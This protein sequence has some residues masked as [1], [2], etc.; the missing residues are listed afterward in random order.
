MIWD[1]NQFNKLILALR[2]LRNSGDV[3]SEPELSAIKQKIFLS[4]AAET[5]SS[6][7][8]LTWTERK[9]KIM[10]YIISILVG[11]SLV[12]GTA[13]ASSGSKPGDLLYPIKRA[14]EKVQ[15]TVAASSE[16]KANLQASFAQERLSELE[17]LEAKN[18]SVHTNS[19]STRVSNSQINNDEGQETEFKAEAKVEV[20]NAVSVLQKLK[21]DL[22]NKGNTEGAKAVAKN[23]SR[24]QSRAK[25]HN[26]KIEVGKSGGEAE[27]EDRESRGS[28]VGSG[29]S[30]PATTSPPRVERENKRSKRSVSDFKDE[31][32]Q[33]GREDFEDDTNDDDRTGDGISPVVIT[34]TSSPSTSA[35]AQTAATYTMVQVQAANTASKCWSVISGKVYNLTSWISQHPGGSSAILGL[36]G[37]DG[38]AA[39]SGQHGGQ[40]RP[41]SEL[42][43]FYIGN[44]K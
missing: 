12:G 37:K 39:F 7:A 5:K 40:A 22:E 13:F 38:T 33:K 30:T 17:K 14:K 42:A 18:K 9:E 15:L 24:L 11:L 1:T 41:A 10:K 27:D 2:S 25:D 35:Q 21:I 28:T 20:Q 16:S 3:L 34:P 31:N 8:R 4:V 26:I 6:P 23:I 29:S 44:L 19:T 36:C 32:K 43:G